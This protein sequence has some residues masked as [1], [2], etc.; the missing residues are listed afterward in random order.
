MALIKTST[1]AGKTTAKDKYPGIDSTPWEVRDVHGKPIL[2]KDGKVQ[3]DVQFRVVN[4]LANKHA[5][6]T[7]QYAK[8]IRT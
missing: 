3:Q 6:E 5:R 2:G 8:A 1:K 7:G 4:N